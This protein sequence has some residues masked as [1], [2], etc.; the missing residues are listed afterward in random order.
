MIE[1]AYDLQGDRIAFV[2]MGGED[3]S[4]SGGDRF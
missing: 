4:N 1:R 3:S 2:K